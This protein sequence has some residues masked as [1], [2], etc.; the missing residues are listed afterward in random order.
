VFCEKGYYNV[1]Q[2]RRILEAGRK[3]GMKLRIHADWLAH[4]GGARLGA[5]LEVVSADHLLFTPKEDIEALTNRGTSGFSYQLLLSVMSA[6]MQKRG[7][8]STKVYLLL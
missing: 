8:S 2:S 4:S 7:K 3:H 5:E 1:E 6:L